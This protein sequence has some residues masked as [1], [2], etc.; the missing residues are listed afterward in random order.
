MTR[1]DIL[2]YVKKKYETEPDFPWFIDPESAVL[3]HNKSRKWYGLL[4]KVAKNK[5]GLKGEGVANI[6]NLK[7][8]MVMASLLNRPEIMPA[9]HMNKR[10]WITVLLDGNLP[11][12]EVYNLIDI[13][14]ELT[15]K[16]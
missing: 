2:D 10:H 11:K 4:M 14:Y 9:Y 3:R 5:L 15:Q 1:E 6:L 16:P 12:E 7:C 8:D 13:S